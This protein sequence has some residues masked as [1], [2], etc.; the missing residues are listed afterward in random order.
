MRIHIYPG[1]AHPQFFQRCWRQIVGEGQI[2]QPDIG[3][4]TIDAGGIDKGT[5]GT[6]GPAAITRRGPLKF[7]MVTRLPPSV[8]RLHGSIERRTRDGIGLDAIQVIV[9]R[10]FGELKENRQ[11][12]TFI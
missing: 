8:L 12:E 6:K 7:G 2:F 1:V 3:V 9:C 4:V 5:R 10:L 11:P